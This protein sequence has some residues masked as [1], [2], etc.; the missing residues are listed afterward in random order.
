MARFQPGVSGNPAGR[1]PGSGKL[2]PL[3]D[4]LEKHR[5]DLLERIVR[6]ALDDAHDGQVVMLKALL[7]RL[8]PPLRPVD[9]GISKTADSTPSVVVYLPVQ[10]AL[11]VDDEPVT[12]DE[13][14]N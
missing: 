8:V 10:D 12:A 5:F 9:S 13:R 6:I 14:Q 1:K 4:A 3:Q 7:D 11:P 2:K